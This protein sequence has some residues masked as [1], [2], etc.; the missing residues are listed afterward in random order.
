MG[1][2]VATR[3]AGILSGTSRSSSGDWGRQC[4]GPEQMVCMHL[5]LEA[6]CK[7]TCW[8]EWRPAAEAR[9]DCRCTCRF[10]D[11][12]WHSSC[13]WLLE[14]YV[15]ACMASG[16][17]CVHVYSYRQPAGD[18]HV[19]G[20]KGQDW[21]WVCAWLL[22]WVLGPGHLQCCWLRWLQWRG[23]KRR[24]SSILIL[25]EVSDDYTNYL[26][27]DVLIRE[28]YKLNVCRLDPAI[29]QDILMTN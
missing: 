20:L 7:Y 4:W 16:A 24:W 2:V 26:L 19:H 23:R 17:S 13:S 3:A 10:E 28:K 8:Q 11:W 22:S 18:V 6:S 21:L 15:G 27:F 25:W 29:K 1:S 5:A 9:A 14:L 12:S